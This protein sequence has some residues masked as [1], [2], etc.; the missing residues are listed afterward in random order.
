MSKVVADQWRSHTK[1]RVWEVQ[2]R[3][4]RGGNFGQARRASPQARTNYAGQ[5]WKLNPQARSGP[6]RGPHGLARG[7]HKSWVTAICSSFVYW[8]AAAVRVRKK[9]TRYLFLI[10]VKTL[11]TPFLIFVCP[12]NSVCPFPS[13][14]RR[15]PTQ[16]RTTLS[17]DLLPPTTSFVH[18]ESQECTANHRSAGLL[19]PSIL[20]L[21]SLP[22]M[23]Y[24]IIRSKCCFPFCSIVT[25]RNKQTAFG[26]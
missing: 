18:R 7:R 25:M 20:A 15:W 14:P 19:P 10:F 21:H 2:T 5:A 12:K 8:Y 1:N 4:T 24:H 22:G 6:A 26:T 16:L 17:N 3:I 9:E 11:E 13:N 23:Y